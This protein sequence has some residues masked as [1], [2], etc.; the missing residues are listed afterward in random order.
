MTTELNRT[1]LT[2]FSKDT[3]RAKAYRVIAAY[4]AAGLAASAAATRYA[5]TLEAN[6]RSPVMQAALGRLSS[7]VVNGKLGAAVAHAFPG[8]LSPDEAVLIM[9]LD[10]VP[11]PQQVILLDRAAEFLERASLCGRGA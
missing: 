5:Q 9:G 7:A 3:D 6:S 8:Q 10:D 1:R 2:A 4:V 11:E